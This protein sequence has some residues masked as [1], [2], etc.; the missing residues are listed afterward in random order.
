MVLNTA[1]YALLLYV[2]QI[3]EHYKG[4]FH[5]LYSEFNKVSLNFVENDRSEVDCPINDIIII[6]ILVG[7]HHFTTVKDLILAARV[8]PTLWFPLTIY[9]KKRCKVIYNFIKC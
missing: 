5:I 4:Q 7:L 3:P 1:T 9:I 8:I 2:F 6:T